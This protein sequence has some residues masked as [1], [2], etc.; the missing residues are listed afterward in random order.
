MRLV[1]HGGAR[2]VGRSCIEI[3]TQSRRL[4]LDCGLKIASHDAEYPINFP[5]ANDIDAAF[6]THA[7]LDHTGALPFLDHRGM[8]CPIFMTKTTRELT[9]LILKDAFKVGKITHQHLGYEEVDIKKV[10]NCIKRVV[11]DTKGN[12]DGISFEFF[13]AGHIPGSA[14][15]YLDVEG[16][17]VLYTG[18]INTGETLLLHE[19]ETEFPE[20]DILICE[21]TYGT[22]DH[23]L[24]PK[25]EERFI[26]AVKDTLSRGGSAIVPVFAIGRAQEILLMLSKYK[27]KAPIYFDGMCVEATNIILSEPEDI[28]DSDALEDA[29]GKVKLVKSDGDRFAAINRP[30]IIVTTSGMMTGGPVM[31]YLNYLYNRPNSSILLTG[32]QAED[33][34]GRLLIEKREVYVDGFRKKVQ[35]R[36]EQFDFS[37]HSGMSQLKSLV[38]QVKPK[39]VF[40]VHGEEHSV[41]ALQEWASALGMEAYAPEL[42]DVI[43]V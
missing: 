42:G 9:R 12:I 3:A 38:R 17:K 26:E 33:T 25:E 14:S 5:T 36:V 8:D 22:R 15:V 21:S 35:C 30:S 11:V 13:D 20:I 32:Y 39:K 4:L 41:L 6:I 19:A 28:I 2:E 29:V 43:D 16:T 7:H 23:P 27:F 24:R 1:F 34:N 40:F 31:R 10:L 18:D 37:A